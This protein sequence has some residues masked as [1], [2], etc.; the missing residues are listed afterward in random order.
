MGTQGVR[1]SDKERNNE[2]G[3]VLSILHTVAAGIIGNLSSSCD[4][5]LQMWPHSETKSAANAH[6]LYMICLV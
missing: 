3:G 4:C 1:T 2:G 5:V 6:W